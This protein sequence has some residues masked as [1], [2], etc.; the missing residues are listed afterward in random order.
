MVGT[1]RGMD[2]N[3]HHKQYQWYHHLMGCLRECT[4]GDH[5]AALAYGNVQGVTLQL[6]ITL[7]EC[8]GGDPAAAH[9]YLGE[10]TGGNP[11]AAPVC[12]KSGFIGR[13]ALSIRFPG[14]LLAE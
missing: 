6:P 3:E 7:W 14:A 5:A 8:T 10:C 11:A 9:F 1:E 2:R 4:W 13:G 12:K